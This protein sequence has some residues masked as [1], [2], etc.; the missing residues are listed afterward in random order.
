MA[1]VT[2]FTDEELAQLKDLQDKFNNIVLQFGQIDIELIKLENETK[3][4]DELKE[5]LST[6]YVSL[7]ET[8]ITLA[9]TLNDKY[10]AGVL[11]PKTGNFTPEENK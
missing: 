3:R 10:G 2:K 9:H 5:K 7:R 11:N 1:E 6:E 8:E 4:L